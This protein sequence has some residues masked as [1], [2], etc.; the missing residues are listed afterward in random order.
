MRTTATK[1]WVAFIFALFAWC[2]AFFGLPFHLDQQTASQIVA[3]IASL[4]AGLVWL[5]PN[6]PK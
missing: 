4:S 3:T 1:F 6:R 2:E 5:L